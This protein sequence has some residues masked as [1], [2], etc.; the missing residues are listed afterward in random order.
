DFVLDA[1]CRHN[2]QHL[3]TDRTYTQRYSTTPY[4]C[5]HNIKDRSLFSSRFVVKKYIGVSPKL[6]GDFTS[7]TTEQEFQS[8]L[9]DFRLRVGKI[10]YLPISS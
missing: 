5:K 3:N 9:G 10:E 2:N 8:R 1:K 6:F 4:V 7:R